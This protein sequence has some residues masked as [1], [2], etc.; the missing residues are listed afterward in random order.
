MHGLPEV[1]FSKGEKFNLLQTYTYLATDIHITCYRH[2]H[3]LLHTYTVVLRAK[4]Y[5]GGL[6]DLNAKYIPLTEPSHGVGNTTLL[7]YKI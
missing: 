7:E 5:G 3:N 4:N 6:N 2:T 1:F